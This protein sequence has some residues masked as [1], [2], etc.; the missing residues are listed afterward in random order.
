VM[1]G[2]DIGTVIMPDAELK[3]FVTASIEERVRRRL[4]QL[5]TQGENISADE[6][7]ENLVARDQA[8]ASR[9]SAPLKKASD[10]VCIDTTNF[11]REGQLE[12]ILALV[13]PLIDPEKYL[14]FIQ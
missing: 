4:K 14:P 12:A 1:D 3:V 8:D 7:R 10:A 5:L 11:T 9:A 2:R 13:R 6:V